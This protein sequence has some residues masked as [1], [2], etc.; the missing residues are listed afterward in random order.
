MKVGFVQVDGHYPNLALMQ[1]CAYHESKGDQVEWYKGRLFDKE[2]GAVYASKIFS[3]SEM[4]DLPD[5]ASIGGTGIDFT[6]NL[7]VEID[8]ML[9]SYSLY[10]E[11]NY[12]LGFSQKGCR[13][14]KKKCP[15]C[16]VPDKEGRP[17]DYWTIEQMLCN[18]KGGD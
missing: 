11:C 18:P 13:M 2:Y 9:P 17:R 4:P 1:V 8:A 6:N 10:P 5:F 15:W 7:P 16:V 3:F 12:H 14:T